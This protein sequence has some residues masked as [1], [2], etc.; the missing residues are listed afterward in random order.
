MRLYESSGLTNLQQA[1]QEVDKLLLESAGST[2]TREI[3]TVQA[4]RALGLHSY[5]CSVFAILKKRATYFHEHPERKVNILIGGDKG[6]SY[7][8]FHFELVALGIVS[9]NVLHITFTFLPC[10]KLSILLKTC[11]S[12]QV[13]P[14]NKAQ[15]MQGAC[16]ARVSFSKR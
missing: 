12:G 6:V 2:M 7:T 10:L 14:C 15:E 4:L 9:C 13:L 1:D 11:S 8:K 5:I 3:N 16:E